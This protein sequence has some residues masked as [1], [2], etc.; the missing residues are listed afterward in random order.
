MQRLNSNN[1]FVELCG[2]V[3]LPIDRSDVV[4]YAC[5]R[6]QHVRSDNDDTTDIDAHVVNHAA[7]IDYH[8]YDATDIVIA[9]NDCKCNR[10]DAYR[11]YDDVQCN[12]YSVRTDTMYLSNVDG[13]GIYHNWSTNDIDGHH[14]CVNR[15]VN[16]CVNDGSANFFRQ[17]V[18]NA[19]IHGNQLPPV[20]AVDV[21]W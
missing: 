5:E 4:R 15:N 6:G 9:T 3:L 21:Y 16:F 11:N 1:D 2:A 17:Y 13:A 10:H 7:G 8:H 14:T 12:W 20:C 18:D 19:R